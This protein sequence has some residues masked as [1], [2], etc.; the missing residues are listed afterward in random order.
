MSNTNFRLNVLSDLF[1]FGMKG[2]FMDSFS[3]K[4]IAIELDTYLRGG[5]IEK[6]S[7]PQ[8][9]MILLEIKPP[10]LS[11]RVSREIFQSLPSAS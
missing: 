9:S 4:A 3:L 10:R 2:E 5:T 1:I 8:K 11:S 7:Q 6:V